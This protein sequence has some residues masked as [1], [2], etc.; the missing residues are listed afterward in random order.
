MGANTGSSAGQRRSSQLARRRHINAWV[1]TVSKNPSIT[2]AGTRDVLGGGWV[3]SLL[4]PG[5]PCLM[6]ATRLLSL[7]LPRVGVF[8]V[9]PGYELFQP[10]QFTAVT[11]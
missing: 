2:K 8:P 5:G 3:L 11:K 10:E 4:D 6:E 1:G 9:W 7:P